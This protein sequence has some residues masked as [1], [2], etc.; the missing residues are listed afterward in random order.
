MR[1]LLKELER[2]FEYYTIEED[3]NG[4]IR[5]IGKR[6]L[7]AIERLPVDVLDRVL[8]SSANLSTLKAAA[9]SCHKLYDAFS[10][11]RE[12]IWREVMISDYGPYIRAL[13]FAEMTL[14]SRPADVQFKAPELYFTGPIFPEE[15][16]MLQ[17][18]RSTSIAFAE[19]S[20]FL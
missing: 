7:S 12:S 2:V 10:A 9:L 6:R 17:H 1:R 20:S 14:T 4:N 3:A 8:A 19:I 11:R 18:Y 13:N 16:R 5:V 15:E